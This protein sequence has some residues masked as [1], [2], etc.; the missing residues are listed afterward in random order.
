MEDI[1][2]HLVFYK[3][4]VEHVHYIVQFFSVEL[5]EKKFVGPCVYEMVH[6]NPYFVVFIFHEGVVDQPENLRFIL[7][8]FP[9]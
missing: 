1:T 2:D 4:R 6:C 9:F 3:R 7:D 8:R 5:E